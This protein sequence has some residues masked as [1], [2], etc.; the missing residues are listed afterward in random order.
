MLYCKFVKSGFLDPY[1]DK[2]KIYYSKIMTT[3]D[4]LCFYFL[5]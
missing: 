4:F 3:D 5:N 1:L 2:V